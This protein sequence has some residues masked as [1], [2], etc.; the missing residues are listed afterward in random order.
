MMSRIGVSHDIMISHYIA[1]LFP[2]GI[3]FYCAMDIMMNIPSVIV[4]RS[5]F[6]IFDGRTSRDSESPYCSC[7]VVPLLQDDEGVEIT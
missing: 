5:K 6:A 2:F 1:S 4:G 7:W 3:S